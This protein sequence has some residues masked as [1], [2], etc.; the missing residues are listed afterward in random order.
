MYFI[1][2]LPLYFHR[3]ECKEGSGLCVQLIWL[4][5]LC[6][7]LLLK[8]LIPEVGAWTYL[9]E[10]T[11]L[12]VINLQL[13][14]TGLHVDMY[15]ISLPFFHIISPYFSKIERKL[16]TY[17][18][19]SIIHGSFVNKIHI[20][21]LVPWEAGRYHLE[22]PGER[23]WLTASSSG[24]RLEDLFSA[25]CHLICDLLNLASAHFHKLL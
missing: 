24:Q 11:T 7:N 20:A 14:K 25:G 12:I 16:Y 18:Q 19:G 1:P 4:D 17:T 3:K 2:G 6:Q 22:S 23:N 5:L 8:I 21:R 13:W 9:P 15:I 10:T